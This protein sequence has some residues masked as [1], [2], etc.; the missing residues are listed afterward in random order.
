MD[1]KKRYGIDRR[2]EDDRRK[3]YDLNY[4]LGGGIERRINVERRRPPE[5]RVGWVKTG[6]WK[7]VYLG[8]LI[9]ADDFKNTEN[10]YRAYR[11]KMAQTL[12][13]V[14]N[15][16]R[17]L[18]FWI[19]EYA[20]VV[21]RPLSN[22]MG[23]IVDISRGGLSFYYPETGYSPE[24]GE[25][26]ADAYIMDIVLVGDNFYLDKVPFKTIS[27]RDVDIELPDT[28][29]T[30]KQCGVKFDGLTLEQMDRLDY[31]ILKY[32]SGNI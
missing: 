29:L 24:T 11:D 14:E 10:I 5:R 15:K 7:S 2:F 4:F 30:I 19:E 17:S 21:L 12:I 22:K 3:A 1:D 13:A 27:E 8:S 31:L 28:S 16:R 6:D 26:R 20:Y 23:Q 9:C 18:R 32:G 25:E